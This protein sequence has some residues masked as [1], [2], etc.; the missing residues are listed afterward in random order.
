M[1]HATQDSF[2]PHL[3][4]Q[5]DKIVTKSL[6]VLL[7]LGLG[8]SQ[9]ESRENAMSWRG[10]WSTTWRGLCEGSS[11]SIWPV[12]ANEKAPC[13]CNYIP[14]IGTLGWSSAGWIPSHLGHPSGSS[15]AREKGCSSTGSKTK[16]DCSPEGKCLVSQHE[17]KV[18]V[19]W[20]IYCFIRTGD[21]FS[22]MLSLELLVTHSWSEILCWQGC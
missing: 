14:L 13:N 19:P 21:S 20:V 10:P 18:K 15:S 6:G 9:P 22:H 2:L 16:N 17:G 11:C 4:I 8:N 3:S 1:L 12:S 5:I 7:L